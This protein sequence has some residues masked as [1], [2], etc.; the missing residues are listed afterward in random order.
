MS[1]K[2]PTCRDVNSIIRLMGNLLVCEFYPAQVGQ[3]VSIKNRL[4]THEIFFPSLSVCGY[5]LV[6]IRAN[7]FG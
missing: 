2:N 5:Q 7:C 3:V 6:C 1:I 4:L